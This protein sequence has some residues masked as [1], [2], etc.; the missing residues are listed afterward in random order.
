MG[1]SRGTNE[2]D[3]GFAITKFIDLGF[4]FAVG[5]PLSCEDASCLL[6]DIALCPVCFRFERKMAC[7][8]TSMES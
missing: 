3:V 6:S 7:A 8:K 1:A 5:E 4:G 2:M